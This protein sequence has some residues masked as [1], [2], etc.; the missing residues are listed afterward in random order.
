MDSMS[1]VSD[2]LSMCYNSDFG[3]SENESI[4][5]DGEE[6]HAY[7]GQTVVAPEEVA[8]LSRAVISEP[9]VSGS[10]SAFVE[11]PFVDD[12]VSTDAEENQEQ[13]QGE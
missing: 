10:R 5:D 12:N 1:T 13:S 8:V 7:L 3:L 9:I 6:V 4:C 11:A 2:I